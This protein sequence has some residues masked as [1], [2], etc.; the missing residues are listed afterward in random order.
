MF[1]DIILSDDRR[2]MAAATRAIPDSVFFHAARDLAATGHPIFI[3]TGFFI[4]EAH[5]PET[6]GLIGAAAI[7]NALARIGK[8]IRFFT[9]PHT[10]DILRSIVPEFPID[11]FPVM[12]PEPSE[13]LAARILREFNPGAVIAIE[14]P[15]PDEAGRFF[16]M[17]H[18]DITPWTAHLENLFQ[19]PV[20]LGIGDGGNELGLGT[21]RSL[22]P[23]HLPRT[24]TCAT[25]TLIGA[26]S[27]DATF[28]LIAALE[29]LLDRNDLLPNP[30][31]VT[32]MLSTIVAAGAVDGVLA[33]PALS[34]DTFTPADTARVLTRLRALTDTLR[35]LQRAIT[36][37]I[38][39]MRDRYGEAICDLLPTS[40]PRT[41]TLGITGHVLLDSQR[42][43]LLQSL[44]PE[45]D[46]LD[47]SI[48]VLADP[49][50]PSLPE[51]LAI[52]RHPL[53]PLLDRPNG[54]PASDIIPSDYP[55]RILEQRPGWLLAQLPDLTLGWVAR[56]S[57][58]L[59]EGSRAG[60]TDSWTLPR[61]AAGHIFPLSVSIDDLIGD[62]SEWI[63]TPYRLG[64][65]SRST[66]D[67]SALVQLIFIRF[68]LL[69]PRHSADQSRTGLR[70]PI[71]D[72]LPGDL[73][74]ALNLDR[75]VRHVGL[76]FPE[77]ILHACLAEGRV[78]RESLAEF[79]KRYRITGVRRIA[80]FRNPAP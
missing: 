71:A 69:L 53:I 38:D 31:L 17:R 39:S 65:R 72:M 47:A 80:A 28:A 77:S 26:T 40:D 37:F 18:I 14:R 42:T 8:Q 54:K 57:L 7:G 60:S 73:V 15:G 52:S 49:S 59:F 33:R 16:T 64:G 20:T 34:V 6:D 21:I 30:D 25:H 48:R 55:I 67:C 27:N 45:F 41:G 23:D 22:L 75:S 68:G 79:R 66:V 76:C 9:D 10:V 12:D 44:L 36:R 4:P 1:F 70:V 58:H 32:D 35:P 78:I 62:A 63:G 50:D 11:S 43:A 24:V 74:F 56:H 29:I 51:T 3:L 13:I 5:V 61:A 19:A 46:H 2:G